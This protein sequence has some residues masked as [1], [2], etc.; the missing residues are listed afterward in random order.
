[1][2]YRAFARVVSAAIL[3]AAL[4]VMP[5]KISL[6]APSY[7][8]ASFTATPLKHMDSVD[9]ELEP[10]ITPGQTLY[11]T[12]APQPAGASASPAKRFPRAAT[13][14]TLVVGIS[15]MAAGICMVALADSY[16]SPA[17]DLYPELLSGL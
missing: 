5:A 4:F 16:K 2:Y 15:M 7:A 6:P 12:P 9:V 1:M 8:A 10:I 14:R 17:D 3:L 11:L 13:I